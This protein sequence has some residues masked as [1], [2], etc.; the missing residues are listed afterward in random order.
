MNDYIID[1]C[2]K[3]ENLHSKYLNLLDKIKNK[4][5]T[6]LDINNL[7]LLNKDIDNIIN[8]I[9]DLDINIDLKY[10]KKKDK[11]FLNKFEE[12]NTT[13][14]IINTLKPYALM[15]QL[16]NSNSSNYCIHCAEC[17][18][19]FVGE[20]YLRRYRQHFNSKHR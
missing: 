2:N 8:F 6:D 5:L 20:D 16:N 17:D 4:K 9:G 14:N 15:L 1:R 10:S 7:N 11:D 19:K 3:I 18:K 12:M 13:N